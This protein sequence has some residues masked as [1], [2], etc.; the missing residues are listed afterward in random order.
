MIVA[1]KIIVYSRTKARFFTEHVSASSVKY[2]IAIRVR[3]Y[4]NQA[5]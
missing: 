3:M 4:F 5:Y 1:V 2:R